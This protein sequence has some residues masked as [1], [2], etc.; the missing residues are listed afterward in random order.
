[1]QWMT[2]GQQAVGWYNDVG[3]LLPT[4]A[5]MD[6]G[7]RN[8]DVAKFMTLAN[9]ADLLFANPKYNE[10]GAAVYSAWQAALTTDNDLGG[11]LSTASQQINDALNH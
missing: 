4:K 2:S 9:D 8:A 5:M 11:I 6:M 10:I 7:K 1:V 3:Y